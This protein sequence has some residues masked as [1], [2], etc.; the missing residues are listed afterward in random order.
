MGSP[1][2]IVPTSTHPPFLSAAPRLI[3]IS[4]FSPTNLTAQ[5]QTSLVGTFNPQRNDSKGIE[6]WA[7]KLWK[8]PSW[9]AGPSPR[10]PTF[11]PSYL[12]RE[13]QQH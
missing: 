2:A 10:A 12:R 5:L 9:P 13:L 7:S 1:I 4:S 8:E 11:S 3:P 6:K